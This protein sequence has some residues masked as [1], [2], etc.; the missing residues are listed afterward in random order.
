MKTDLLEQV[1]AD[2]GITGAF[3]ALYGNAFDIRWSNRHLAVEKEQKCR[4]TFH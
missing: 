4:S 3:F 2:E 1:R